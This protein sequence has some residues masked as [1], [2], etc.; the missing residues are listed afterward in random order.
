MPPCEQLFS[1]TLAV[2]P[3]IESEAPQNIMSLAT[4]RAELPAYHCNACDMLAAND[5]GSLGL[6]LG[7][8]PSQPFSQAFP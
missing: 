1:L 2:P 6:W 4:Q 3:K 7:F 5:D 8:W